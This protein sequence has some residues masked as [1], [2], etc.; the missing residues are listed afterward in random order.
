MKSKRMTNRIFQLS[1]PVYLSNLIGALD[2]GPFADVA[3]L[4]RTRKFYVL[5][6][7]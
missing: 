1:A 3:Q 4:L 5:F 2:I 6:A 7:G